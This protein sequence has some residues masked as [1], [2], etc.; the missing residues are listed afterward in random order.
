MP[1]NKQMLTVV[2][3]GQPVAIEGNLQA[4]LHTVV[5]QALKAS[6]NAGEPQDWEL[7]D[8][9]GNLLDLDRKL[10]DFGFVAGVT[11][12]LNRKAGIGG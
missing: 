8:T 5:P 4:P 2:V 6:G 12:Y 1:N 11:L 9:N 10:K 3:G 7:R